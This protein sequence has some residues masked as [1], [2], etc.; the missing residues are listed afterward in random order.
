[1][2]AFVPSKVTRR[3]RKPTASD[4]E[5]DSSSDSSDDDDDDDDGDASSSDT[6]E[7]SSKPK[8]AAELDDGDAGSEY[9]EPEEEE[10][11]QADNDQSGTRSKKS[12]SKKSSKAKA[13]GEQEENEMYTKNPALGLLVKLV[14]A[15][16][17]R[18]VVELMH[19]VDEA[20]KHQDQELEL[21][22]ELAASLA[23]CKKLLERMVRQ[24]LIRHCGAFY[25][26]QGRVIG[27][28]LSIDTNNT[29]VL[30][31]ELDRMEQWWA[32][33]TGV[34]CKHLNLT[35]DHQA[36][37]RAVRQ[38]TLVSTV[39]KLI[40]TSNSSILAERL[41]RYLEHQPRRGTSDA[42]EDQVAGCFSREHL[43]TRKLFRL[44]MSTSM[45]ASNANE[46]DASAQRPP[47]SASS[48]SSSSSSL[49]TPS[50]MFGGI[51]PPP[52]QFHFGMPQ[53]TFMPPS[54]TV[55][56]PSSIISSTLPMPTP[57]VSGESESQQ[58]DASGKSGNDS[59][60]NMASVRSQLLQIWTTSVAELYEACIRAALR[61]STPAAY[62][63]SLLR[64]TTRL[65]HI[66]KCE[67]FCDAPEFLAAVVH[68]YQQAIGKLSNEESVECAVLHVGFLDALLD[69]AH[70][71]AIQNAR[72]WREQH[73]M[74][75]QLM[76]LAPTFDE[77][78]RYVYTQKLARRVLRARH[79]SVEHETWFLREIDHGLALSSAHRILKDAAEAQ[80][81]GPQFE[82]FVLRQFDAQSVGGS[83]R[84]SATTSTS[85]AAL[86]ISA[87][88]CEFVYSG[89]FSVSLV[90]HGWPSGCTTLN[91][92]GGGALKLPE[93]IPQ[94][95]E[96]FRE[97]YAQRYPM[98]RLTISNADGTA[99]VV[100]R[101]A[102]HGS[103]ELTV[104]AEQ[105][106]ILM[107][108]NEHEHVQFG[109]L[110]E[111]LGTDEASVSSALLSLTAPRHAVLLGPTITNAQQPFN[112]A[113][114]FRINAEY[115]PPDGSQI[116]LHT[117]ELQGDH[118]S[119]NSNKALA[120]TITWRRSLLDAAIVR[121]AKRQATAIADKTLVQQVQEAVQRRFQASPSDIKKR[122]QALTAEGILKEHVIGS[123]PAVAAQGGG[124]HDDPSSSSSLV[125]ISYVHDTSVVTSTTL[126]LAAMA[127]STSIAS[128]RGFKTGNESEYT[129]AVHNKEFLASFE[130]CR[131]MILAAALSSTF[132]KHKR[133]NGSV[134][135]VLETLC[136]ALLSSVASQSTN[137]L[138]DLELGGGEMFASVAPVVLVTNQ[139]R[140]ELLIELCTDP[141]LTWVLGKAMDKLSGSTFAQ[142]ITKLLESTPPSI[143]ESYERLV[144]ALFTSAL[145][146]SFAFKGGRKSLL[147][148]F[149][150]LRTFVTVVVAN[151][152]HEVSHVRL[153]AEYVKDMG[154]QHT[155]KEEEHRRMLQFAESLTNRFAPDRL[156][157]VYARLQTVAPPKPASGD[158]EVASEGSE[159]GG[160]QADASSSQSST[161]ASS[162]ATSY[163]E[164]MWSEL[165]AKHDEPLCETEQADD[166]EHHD[167]DVGS[168]SAAAAASAGDGTTVSGSTANELLLRYSTDK[169]FFSTAGFMP[170]AATRSLKVD[171]V[172]NAMD[173]MCFRVGETLHLDAAQSERLLL[174]FSW[175]ESRAIDQF[176][177]NNAESRALAGL[178][179]SEGKAQRGQASVGECSVCWESVAGEE[180]AFALWCG[181]SFCRSCW[182]RHLEAKCASSKS[183][184]VQTRCMFDR[185][186]ASLSTAEIAELCPEFMAAY[187]EALVSSYIEQSHTLAWCKNP[188]A[189]ASVVSL[190]D[191][192]STDIVKCTECNY[193]FC[194]RCP[195]PSHRP[196]TC[197]MVT[198][199]IAMGGY[200]EME[201]E[202]KKAMQLK[203]LISRPCP[204]CG[205]PIEKNGGCTYRAAGRYCQPAS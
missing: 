59:S 93:P 46:S 182:R 175:Q 109:Q 183:E 66:C 172:E 94:L 114:V 151:R 115:A 136:R 160:D 174:A 54:T 202:E 155:S 176:V 52:P 5:S 139:Q 124:T 64:E 10:D 32:W 12:K 122:I 107:L 69:T 3:S 108:L 42:D 102:Q 37:L 83:E 82:A 40:L 79:V 159:S 129:K 132:V 126:A 84:A 14:F 134:M 89:G 148:L 11:E 165:A 100:V 110:L 41:Q 15:I 97:F 147:E 19:Y 80:Q 7:T 186:P 101:D 123:N 25:A 57:L 45:P 104:S 55:Y 117:V 20:R 121:I 95:H 131:D 168:T 47:A 44:M 156:A 81:L 204:S 154:M 142:A 113:D 119:H 179:P 16:L 127:N 98:R 112:S 88:A 181:H 163:V 6:D 72:Q 9:D 58:A 61:H 146:A 2:G 38:S 1:M 90:S 157:A 65:Q 49:S 197:E 75:Q 67:L 73:Q 8:P 35:P 116:T 170:T 187:R 43:Y 125:L 140:C 198:D 56:T 196:V 149:R 77:A 190:G 173:E 195:Y 13:D 185:C 34:L 191:S 205:V 145:R 199:W 48:S 99:T 138:E 22:I 23:G 169:Q 29:V 203:M 180:D 153:P 71:N 68:A 103:Y 152:A 76:P 74:M 141:T 135:N 87:R 30:E 50:T 26:L 28:R 111:Q 60:G 39:S 27:S 78:F 194:L 91:G 161:A 184:R 128:G 51:V 106:C 18:S 188:R 105:L 164:H 86:Q 192:D 53:P 158:A 4:S 166:D 177:S 36:A 189:C 201:E 162:S 96:A 144:E 33:E 70:A 63:S 24:P 137:L 193:G 21:A 31:N 62:V 167:A 133:C 120:A 92:N 85:G 130:S 150:S 17:N 200:S 143:V 178:P 171:A 118:G